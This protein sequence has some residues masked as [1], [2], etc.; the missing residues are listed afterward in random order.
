M[1]DRLPFMFDFFVIYLSK[2]EFC[3][4]ITFK[5]IVISNNRRKDGTYPVKIRVT[6]KGVSRRLPTTLVC[7][8]N[9]LTRSLKIKSATILNKSDELINRMR[10]AV[11]D[12]SPFDLESKDVDWVVSRIK[13]ALT[14]ET[15]NLDFFEWGEKYILTK[16]HNT[17]YAYVSA[18]NALERFLGRRT[19]DIND[20]TRTMLMEFV[21]FVD[22]EPKIHYNWITKESVPTNKERLNKGASSRHLMKLQ[23]LFNAAKD[24]YNDEDCNRIL[25]PKSPFDKIPKVFPAPQGQKNLGQELMQ[26][27][28]DAQVDNASIRSAL[29]VFILS[30]GL[31][32]A[33]MA[34]LYL[35]TP[36]KEEWIYNRQK[37]RTRRADRAEMRVVIPPEM[38]PYIERLQ[39]APGS[40]W[41]PVLHRMASN[42]N[43]ATA[44][45][46]DALKK[47]CEDNDVPPF[48][49][50]AARHTWASL[51]RKAGV[52]KATIDECLC[53]KGDFSLTDIYAE[54]SWDLMTEAN[55]KV[56]DLFKW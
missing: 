15:F 53:H 5:A 19:L 11:K 17:R 33:N 38:Q 41:L 21:E 51:A 12:I 52:E 56:L 20:I 34:D 26:R 32:G 7:T 48:T 25:I 54:R 28:I 49:F 9:D 27:I 47:W 31:M 24:R 3:P 55:R 46:N 50:Y 44:K 13:D 16:S 45:V 2:T 39:D 40:W 14:G 37:T 42:K 30:F 43:Y 18:M 36:I 4:M 10:T 6:F 23:H 1:A 29:D 35:A 8:T 22:N